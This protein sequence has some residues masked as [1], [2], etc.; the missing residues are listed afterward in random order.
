MTDIDRRGFMRGAAATAAAIGASTLAPSRALASDAPEKHG[1]IPLPPPGT[2]VPVSMYA[3]NVLLKLN[4]LGALTLAFKG[5]INLQ[6]KTSKTDGLVMEVQGFRMEADTSPSTP[7]SGT[8]ITMAMSNMTTTP[9]SILQAASGAGG[10]EMLIYLSLT[11][12]VIDKATGQTTS[13]LAT[14]PTT[15]ATLKATDVK[16]FPPVDQLCKLQEPVQLYDAQ[17]HVAGTL[18]GF[19]A[20][21]SKA[22]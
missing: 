8:L 3:A 21:M 19:N 11:V 6:V 12:D 22:G 10:L 17:G 5:G 20:I 15:Y 4:T 2:D 7:K 14:D 9:L 1:T 16:E 18:E 13:M